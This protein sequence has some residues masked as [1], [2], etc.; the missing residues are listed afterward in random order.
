MS[1]D[2]MKCLA[3]EFRADLDAQLAGEERSGFSLPSRKAVA[4]I[5]RRYLEILFPIYYL[6]GRRSGA[7]P[8]ALT[9]IRTLLCKQICSAVRFESVARAGS[10]RKD[11]EDYAEEIYKKLL[12]QL[13][14]LAHL[15]ATDIASGIRQ[16]SRRLQLRGNSAGLPVH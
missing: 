9:E 1:A 7:A 2:D 4:V 3:Q 14:E 6:A 5:C 13:P 16:R 15:L 11:L 10:R 8:P 12:G